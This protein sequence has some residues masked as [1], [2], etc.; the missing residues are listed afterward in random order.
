MRH[1]L[2]HRWVDSSV[3]S[4]RQAAEHACLFC[5]C[6]T[7]RC[8]AIFPPR[9]T[10][11]AH[12]GLAVLWSRIL[13]AGTQ[14]SS[15][16]VMLLWWDSRI[17]DCSVWKSS[18]EDCLEQFRKIVNVRASCKRHLDDKIEIGNKN[19]DCGMQPHNNI[20]MLC[21]CTGCLI[22]TGW[23]NDCLM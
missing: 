4:G 15:H 8:G 1:E 6:C 14:S 10:Q 21:D 3:P 9:S 13:S 7:L 11:S 20:Y 5:S 2:S 23:E 16:G 12:S 17:Y 19:S 22:C 18:L